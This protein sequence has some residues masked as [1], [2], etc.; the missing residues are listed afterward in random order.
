MVL[1][2]QVVQIFDWMVWLASSALAKN[3]F[4]CLSVWDLT[5]QK[6]KVWPAESTARYRYSPPL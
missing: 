5:E 4:G 1:L 3:R 2:D 6:L